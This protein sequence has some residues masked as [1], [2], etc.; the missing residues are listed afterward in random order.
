M[1]KT[2]AWCTDVHLD[3]TGDTEFGTV[4]LCAAIRVRKSD[5]VVLTG[6]ISTGVQL[7]RHLG[8]MQRELDVP[9][10]FVCGN[11]DFWYA[12]VPA[13]RSRLATLA[14]GPSRLRYLS[15][16]QY[17]PITRSTAIVGH[18]GW[19]DGM[20]GDTTKSEFIMN[21]WRLIEE[22]KPCFAAL[23]EGRGTAQL[24]E[25]ARRLARSG[26]AHV[27]AGARAAAVNYKNVIVATHF[28]PFVQAAQHNGKQ[29]D[30]GVLP[31][32][33]SKMMGDAL[34]QLAQEM[35]TTT[36]TVLCGHTHSAWSGRILSN[37]RVHVGA[38]VYGSP[39]VQPVVFIE[40]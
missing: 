39:A 3:C 18:D 9:I 29:Q 34:I 31:W 14:S 16:L 4:E 33:T 19:Y 35:P 17:V 8:I 27:V 6:D 37:L 23:C 5:G 28:L 32:Y 20:N 26:V 30:A 15:A 7:E 40:D 10:W 1:A 25:Q 36:F 12:S 24:L 22:F 11:H 13:L 38:A 21:D 2:L